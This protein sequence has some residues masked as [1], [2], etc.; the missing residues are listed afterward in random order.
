MPEAPFSTTA[1]E[2]PAVRDDRVEWCGRLMLKLRDRTKLFIGQR[3]VFE[4]LGRPFCIEIAVATD[5]AGK[6]L[7]TYLVYGPDWGIVYG[8]EQNQGEFTKT[9]HVRNTSAMERDVA[10]LMMTED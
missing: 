2:Y 4:A 8:I 5:G 3:A 1:L 7:V 6:R 9:F 10:L